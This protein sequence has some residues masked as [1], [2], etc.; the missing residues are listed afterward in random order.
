MK[1]RGYIYILKNDGMKGLIKIGRTIND[2]EQR[3]QQLSSTGVPFPFKV[4]YKM[5]VTD[6]KAAEKW[7][8][9]KFA[10]KR[11]NQGR[12]FF[13]MEAQEA[14]D[15]LKEKV[16]PGRLALEKSQKEAE[17]RRKIAEM[18]ELK[19]REHAKFLLEQ[20]QAN[21]RAKRELQNKLE[22][23]KQA[24]LFFQSMFSFGNSVFY[25]LFFSLIVLITGLD[26]WLIDT[27]ASL[28]SSI[29]KFLTAPLY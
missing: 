27:L 1:T 21:I 18:K 15:A 11:V 13:R 10:H 19:Y 22:R 24:E 12:E 5:K 6:C 3:A 16:D 8:H 7:L 4:A 20:E 14:F 2:P 28:F 29:N 9:Q 25:L 23:E 17:K 26:S